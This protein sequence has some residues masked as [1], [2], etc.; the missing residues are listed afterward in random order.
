MNDTKDTKDTP[1]D[2]DIAQTA[3]PTELHVICTSAMDDEEI[4]AAMLA[5]SGEN[6]SPTTLV[7]FTP[8]PLCAT[9]S[10]A[11]QGQS[12]CL[13]TIQVSKEDA[14]LRGIDKLLGYFHDLAD[15][16]RPHLDISFE[17]VGG[18][19]FSEKLSEL[20]AEPPTEDELAEFLAAQK[21]AAE[22]L[23]R[24]TV[25]NTS[26]IPTVGVPDYI[27][28]LEYAKKIGESHASQ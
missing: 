7:I 17:I 14:S 11:T 16:Y 23:A 21:E 1:L 3:A 2:T 25:E 24:F 6:L 22:E 9:L 26:Y 5:K 20:Y 13:L 12:S 10:P 18:N 28:C 27:D 19:T 8:V 15:A 4:E